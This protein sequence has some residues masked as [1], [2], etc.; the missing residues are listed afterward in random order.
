MSNKDVF[1]FFNPHWIL[2]GVDTYFYR[3]ICWLTDRE[4]ETYLLLPKKAPI[5][6]KFMEDVKK[7]GVTVMPCIERF[8]VSNEMK[9]TKV[10]FDI[11]TDKTIYF[12][13]TRLEDYLIAQ[14]IA[15]A[16]P[17]NSFCL[18]SYMLH[19]KA[20][21]RQK[22]ERK[23]TGLPRYLY[24]QAAYSYYRKILGKSTVFIMD[25]ICRDSY[26][27]FYHTRLDDDIMLPVGINVGTYTR[28]RVQKG[29]KFVILTVCRFEFPYKGY[30]LGLIKQFGELCDKY[31]NLELQI[32][33]WGNGETRV[34]NEIMQLSEEKQKKVKLIGRVN[35]ENLDDYILEA[36]VYVGMGT[37]LL[38]AGKMGVPAI[39]VDFFTE[40]SLSNQLLCDNPD[41]V[42]CEHRVMTS[43]LLERILNY[44][45]E[46]YA[47]CCYD[48]YVTVKEH[49]SIDSVME[50]ILRYDYSKKQYR[51]SKIELW[52]NVKVK[53]WVLKLFHQNDK[54]DVWVD[55]S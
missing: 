29:E 51:M 53:E 1:M 22:V 38:D 50:K 7:T 46:E 4:Y 55:E 19:V 27:S 2:G 17:Q 12:I 9:P 26:E 6:E 39:A 10:K 52:L 44:S 34:C 35:Y 5:E 31:D 20:L 21:L 25:S 36:N 24:N 14:G 45:D 40:E 23:E 48:T 47:K 18:I 13:S 30:V 37:T 42:A 16:N 33:G 54:V 8:D 11:S 28:D 43:E 41:I 49:Y 15:K 3:M 32:I